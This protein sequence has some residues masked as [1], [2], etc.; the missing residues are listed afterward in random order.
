MT[1]FIVWVLLVDKMQARILETQG[2]ETGLFHLYGRVYDAPRWLS[3][4]DDEGR[5]ILSTINRGSGQGMGPNLSGDCVE[6]CR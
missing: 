4:S 2:P 3:H 6:R 5:E 1:P